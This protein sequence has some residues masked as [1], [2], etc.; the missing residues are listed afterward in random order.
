MNNEVYPALIIG[1][2]ASGLL[3]G[4]MLGRRAIILERNHEPGRKLML[5]GGGRCNY[6]HA[7][8]V[9]E[10]LE[11]YNGPRNAIRKILYRFPPDRIISYFRSLGIDECIEPGGKVFPSAGDARTITEVLASGCSIAYGETVRSLSWEDGIFLAACDHGTYRARNAIVTSGCS[12]YPATGSD[13]KGLDILRAF[14]H[15]T[16]PFTPAM[17]PLELERRLSGAEGITLDATIRCGKKTYDGS[18]VITGKG[19]SGP[20]AQNVSYLLDSRKEIEISFCSI[21]REDIYKASGKT[22]LK[23]ALPVPDRLSSAI[24]GPVASKRIGD[25]RKDEISMAV[26]SLTAFRT[27]ARAIREGAMTDYGGALLSG[28]SAETMESAKQKG[29]YA[30]GDILE[31]CADCGGYSLTFAFATAFIAASSVLR[32]LE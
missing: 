17:A 25:L 12:A 5:T 29:L 1:A 2:G 23:N 18:I 15:D 4:S 28:F 32:S 26:R 16:V 13:G 8:S 22:L 27:G 30:A 11:H 7:S 6:T 31:P 21:S 9:P 3:A 19:I 10:L 24:L 14:G 20:A